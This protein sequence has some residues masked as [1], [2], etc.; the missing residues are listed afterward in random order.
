MTFGI[1]KEI[2]LFGISIRAINT[3]AGCILTNVYRILF[4]ELYVAISKFFNAIDRTVG[5][6]S[7]LMFIS[8]CYF[9]NI[10][11]VVSLFSFIFPQ[12]AVKI[13]RKL[14]F[15]IGITMAGINVVYYIKNRLKLSEKEYK[16]QNTLPRIL[17]YI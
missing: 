16:P 2:T 3:A 7:T 17:A 9:C 1:I 10:H 15:A 12:S 4:I 8:I 5:F 6:F 14:Y 13:P 11:T